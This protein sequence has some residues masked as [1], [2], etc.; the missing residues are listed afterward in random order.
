MPI[1]SEFAFC[2]IFGT[3][4]L[5]KLGDTCSCI[6]LFST[7]FLFVFISFPALYCQAIIV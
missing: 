4:L 5:H 2:G 7:F 1:L 3:Q 6:D